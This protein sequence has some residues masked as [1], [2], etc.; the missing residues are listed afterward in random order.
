[1]NDEPIQIINA[2]GESQGICARGIVHQRGLRHRSTNVF[3]FSTKNELL[4]QCR[5]ASKDVY[6]D[7]WDLSVAEHARP[8]EAPIETAERGLFEEIG[9]QLEQ[10]DF[11]IAQAGFEAMLVLPARGDRRA[12]IDREV[13]TSF[14]CTHDGPF[15]LDPD[16]VSSTRWADRA[17]LARIINDEPR[18]LTP[19]LRQRLAS[20]G[21]DRLFGP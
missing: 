11:S 12:I 2:V 14:R 6:P 10:S 8:F 21:I 15:V 9:V 1:M 18:T 19:W 13:T 7:R 3:V 17:E 16:E 20:I 4:L 5:S